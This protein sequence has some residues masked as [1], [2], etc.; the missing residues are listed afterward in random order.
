MQATADRP[1]VEDR[2]LF[3]DSL[4]GF[5]AQAWPIESAVAWSAEPSRLGEV[6]RALAQQGV[7]A[8]GFD[9]SVGGMPEI[10][11]AMEELGR[12]A[13]RAPV[14]PSMLMNLVAGKYA[15]VQTQIAPL[16]AGWHAGDGALCIAFGARDPDLTA[17]TA[18]YEG[19]RVSGTVRFVEGMACATHLAIAVSDSALAIVEAAGPGVSRGE[20]PSMDLRDI[21][22][23]TL[24]RAES[25]FIEIG[26]AAMRDMLAAARL[27]GAARAL[28][29]ASRAFDLVVDHVKERVQFGKPVGSFQAIQHKLANGHIALQAVRLSIEHAALQWDAASAHRHWY[30]AAASALASSSLRQVSL[31]THHAFGAIG[32]SEEHEAPRHFRTVHLDALRYGGARQANEEVASHFLDHD[33]G[34]PA[35]D[36]GAAGNTFR[37]EVREW[38]RDNWGGARKRSHDALPFKEREFNA[39]F[40]LQLGQTGWIGLSWPKRFGGQERSTLEQLA[41]IEE[42]ERA[43]APRV[44]APV[45]AV[46]LQVFGTPEQQARYLPEILRGEAMF[47]MG[48]SEPQAGSDLAALKTRAVRDGDDYVINGQKIWTTTYWGKYMLLATRTRP[49]AKLAHAGLSMFIVPMSA[50]GIT[51]HTS[52]TLY[53]GTFANVFYDDVRVPAD[54]MVGGEG[55][56]WK[57]LTEALATERGLEGGGIVLKVVHLF[58]LLCAH[59]RSASA[60]GHGLRQD[61]LVRFR[62]DEL[63]GQIEAA[64]QMMLQCARALDQGNLDLAD[65]AVSKVYSGELLERFGECALDILGMEGAIS[66]GGTGAILNGRIEQSLRHSLMWAISIGTNEIQRN[67]IAQRALELPR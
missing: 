22:E 50:P 53:G 34:F 19:G 32:Y 64:R 63:A 52:T 36:L 2:A 67:L 18:H 58:E 25:V 31:E 37:L 12:A 1:T 21:A 46:M 29:A 17:G 38:L 23:V 42:M 40:A 44:G 4:R 24:D 15:A 27:A 11:V 43:D 10:A 54:A 56:G 48:Y 7:T 14:V 57:V 55:E 33:G 20:M 59:L 61:P 9:A 39:E 41:F 6:T 49:D 8:L 47:G 65:A 62:I 45:Q 66:Q 30:A 13:C 60:P 3:R 16:L 5:L 35:Y 28:G 51:V 26:T